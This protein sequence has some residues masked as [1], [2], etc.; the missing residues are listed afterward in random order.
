MTDP[1]KVY[2]V[3]KEHQGI[4]ADHLARLA[5]VSRKYLSS[6]V[7]Q[8]RRFCDHGFT[9]ESEIRRVMGVTMTRYYIVRD[10]NVEIG[11]RELENVA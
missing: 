7:C 6:K 8:A 5:E 9:I 11:Q 1:E 2:E 10:Y 4:E 3:L